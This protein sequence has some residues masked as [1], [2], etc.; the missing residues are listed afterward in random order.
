MPYSSRTRSFHGRAP[1]KRYNAPKKNRSFGQYIDPQRFIA[2]ARVQAAEKYEPVHAFTDFALDNLLQKNLAYAGYKVPS[3]IQDQA[4]PVGLM[5]RDVIG[6][7]GT[8]TG[9]TAAFAL[10]LLQRLLNDKHGTALIL[11]P[12]R[13]LAQQIEQECRKLS[14]GSGLK[15]CV[16]I[17]GTSMQP[18]LRQ[19]RA[20][21]RLIVGTPGRVKDHLERGTL[22]LKNC[23]YVVLDEVDRMLD[24]GFIADIREVIGRTN[25]MR[26]SLFFSATSNPKIRSL[27][28]DL[29]NDPV[30]ITI[31]AVAASSNV[32]QDVI[33]YT[34]QADK[35]EKLHDLL[36][37][38]LATKVII[39]DETQRNVERLTTELTDRGFKTVAIHGGKTQGHRQR[40]LKQ[41]KLNEVS[42]M[43]ATD[44]AARGLDVSDITHVVNYSVPQQYED[45]IHRVG[46]AGRAGRTGYAFTFVAHS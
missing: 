39:F 6:I 40:A 28:D 34:A 16:L 9:K 24:M 30:E 13:E 23:N 19:L 44:V 38:D 21:P 29:T 3:P 4:I 41:F 25:P 8:G 22:Q 1:K 43:V 26:Q 33:R 2:P 11:A 10:P 45:Y 18:Q 35:M 46:R 27:M 20:N 37:G 12:T 5:G 32:H 7:A 14:H 15:P 36:I 42:I 17:G 31:A